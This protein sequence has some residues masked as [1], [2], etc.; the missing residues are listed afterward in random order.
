MVRLSR[1]LLSSLA[2]IGLASGTACQSTSSTD[3]TLD[4]DDFV[5]GSSSPNPTTAEECTDGRTYRVVRGN[6]QPDDILKYD[7]TATFTVTVTINK[8]ASDSD[9]DLN[10]PVT[11]T[12]ATA[13][14][15][16]ATNGILVP[17]TSTETEHYESVLLSTTGSTFS[18]TNTTITMTMKVWYD[19][20]D[21]GRE[22]LATA[23]IAFEDDDGVTFTKNV[24]CIIK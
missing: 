10:F 6:E 3:D 18:G 2:V 14:V 12:S 17:S 16:Q 20:P 8:N 4:V 22:A 13:T 15:K 21:L 19:L 23:S 11:I 7:Y 5:D 9:I 1:L 24:K